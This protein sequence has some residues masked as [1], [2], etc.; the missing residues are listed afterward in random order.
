MSTPGGAS[1]PPEQL[2]ARYIGTGKNRPKFFLFETKF[3]HYLH[4]YIHNSVFVIT[5][6]FQAMLTLQNSK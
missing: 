1:I 2:K 3:I 4:A 6:I 5:I